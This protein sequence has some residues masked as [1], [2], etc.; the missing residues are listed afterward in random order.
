MKRSC[1]LKRHFPN[2]L[3]HHSPEGMI[4]R[5]PIMSTRKI[6]SLHCS[7]CLKATSSSIS[8]REYRT[9][10]CAASGGPAQHP[11]AHIGLLANDPAD[12][13]ASADLIVKMFCGGGPMVQLVIPLFR[14]S[15][16][17][18]VFLRPKRA[19]LRV[20]AGRWLPVVKVD[21]AVVSVI[22]GDAFQAAAPAVMEPVYDDVRHQPGLHPSGWHVD[23]KLI[24]RCTH[25]THAT[26]CSFTQPVLH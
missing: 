18:D 19:N 15:L 17:Y 24:L 16:S 11:G 4:E 5:L 21:R 9:K 6:P 13:G 20:L 2:I 14:V 8:V 7:R 1:S 25:P 26:S 23:V 3:S 22:S 10:N 12:I